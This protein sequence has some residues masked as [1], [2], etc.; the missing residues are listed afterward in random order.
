M[1]SHVAVPDAPFGSRLREHQAVCTGRK[2]LGF[3]A[4][5]ALFN[6]SMAATAVKLATGLPHE[7]T[8]NTFLYT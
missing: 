1:G 6:D 7:K 3:L 8:I 5:R 4:A 2:L